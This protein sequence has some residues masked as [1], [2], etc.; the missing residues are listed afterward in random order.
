VEWDVEGRASLKAD[1]GDGDATEM[2]VPSQG[3]Q[4]PAVEKRTTFTIRALDAN[5]AAPPAFASQSVDVAT[6]PVEK[7]TNAVCDAVS[8]KCRGSFAIRAEGQPVTVRSLSAPRVVQAGNARPATICVSHDGLPPTCVSGDD[9]VAVAVPAQGLW[10][11]AT[12]LPADYAGPPDPQLRIR[13][14]FGCP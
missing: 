7:G 3:E 6:A 8:R 14:G 9:S 10:E 11:L 1:R 13:L 4:A 12:D 2:E 5:T